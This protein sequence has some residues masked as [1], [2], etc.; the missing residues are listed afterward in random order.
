MRNNTDKKAR[1]IKRARRG[2]VLKQAL[3]T[4]FTV[5][6]HLWDLCRL[7]RVREVAL[8]LGV[9]EMTI[10]KWQREGKLPK[11]I[12]V[13]VDVTSWRAVDISEWLAA[14]QDAQ[15]AQASE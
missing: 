6:E 5:P 9:H 14:K 10:W 11:P 4:H 7:L 1:V 2:A 8:L 12:K 3:A 15:D 13:G